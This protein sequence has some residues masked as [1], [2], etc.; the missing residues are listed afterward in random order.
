MKFK[1]SFILISFFMLNI[2]S[3][4]MFKE[5]YENPNFDD[6]TQSHKKIAIL[7]FTVVI[8]DKA[9]PEGMSIDELN[10][11]QEDEGKSFQTSVFSRFLKKSKNYRVSFQD[12]DRTNTLLKKNEIEHSALDE[13]TKDEIAKILGV[14][15]VISGQVHRDKPMKAGAAVALAIFTGFGGATN[16]AKLYLTIHNGIDGDLL[17]KYNHRASGGI[18]SDIEGVVTRLMKQVA[19]KFPYKK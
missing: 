14:D 3:A 12:I 16:K 9:L 1:I 18:G 13:Y 10:M 17:W 11:Q 19:R 6:L 15:A 5:I 8:A 2:L 7:P 4:Q